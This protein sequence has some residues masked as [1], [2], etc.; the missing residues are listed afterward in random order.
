[1]KVLYVNARNRAPQRYQEY[2]RVIILVPLGY[3]RP[4]VLHDILYWFL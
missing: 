2:P 4:K 3:G 1:M